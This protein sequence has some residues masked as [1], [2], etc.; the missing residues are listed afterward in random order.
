MGVETVIDPQAL[1]EAEIKRKQGELTSISI[2]LSKAQARR[3]LINDEAVRLTKEIE[4]GREELAD[5]GEK[6]KKAEEDFKTHNARSLSLLEK[7]DLESQV[8][9]DKAEK[10]EEAARS[11]KDKANQARNTLIAIAEDMSKTVDKI[12]ALAVSVKSGVD[13]ELKDF[14]ALHDVKAEIPDSKPKK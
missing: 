4:K 7:R 9:M 8:R 2:E 14:L 12:V 3:D 6:V 10:A 1:Y 13:A 5:T 11:E